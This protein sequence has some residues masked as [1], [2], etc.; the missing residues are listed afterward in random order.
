MY[1]SSCRK[2]FG[3]SVRSRGRRR[4][5]Q[6]LV[7][8]AAD[9]TIL[10]LVL[11][12]SREIRMQRQSVQQF[13]VPLVETRPHHH[14]RPG[15][16]DRLQPFE[17]QPLDRLTVGHRRLEGA[18]RDKA[19]ADAL[20][21]GDAG[22]GHGAAQRLHALLLRARVEHMIHAA[23]GAFERLLVVRRDALAFQEAHGENAARNRLLV[24]QENIQTPAIKGVAERRDVGRGR[25]G[26]GETSTP[27]SNCLRPARWLIVQR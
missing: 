18:V 27:Y 14:R 7:A 20:G 21:V 24:H 8:P 9:A 19:D 10:L 17:L 13:P 26:V 16:A 1:V 11:R 5:R 2:K 12:Q 4:F 15:D 3:Q 22:V 23:A 6:E 25:A